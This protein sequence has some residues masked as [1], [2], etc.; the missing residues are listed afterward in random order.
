MCG[1]VGYTGNKSVVDILIDGLKQLEYRGYDSSGIAVKCGDDIKV[2][3]AEGKLENLS[4]VLSGHVSEFTSATCGIGHIRW[5]THGAPT[6]L[7]AH[8]HTCT[9][10][11]LVIVHNGIIE[12]YKEL[13]EQLA[14]DGCTFRSQ[15]DT[16]VVAHLVAKK[17]AQ[18][19]DL[20]EAVR[21]AAK[22]LEG[23]YALCV[24]H[25]DY[26]NTIVA[27]KRN[28]PLLV[29]VGEGEFYAAS[30]VPAIIKHTNR[31]MYL[32]DNE[33]VTLTPEKMLL[34]NS[35]GKELQ[36][37]IET[38]PWEPVALSKRGYKHFMLKE[39]HEQP[40]VI[41]NILVGKLHAPDEHI[42]LNEVKLNKDTLK[43]LNRIQIIAC[44]TSLHAA[45]VGKYLI[46]NF[47]GIAVDVEASSE[48]IY[49]KTVTDNHTLVIGVSQSGETADTLT[50]IKQAKEKG[51]HALIIT[52]R[53]DSAMARLADS[54]IS[55]NAGIEV[56]VAATK[57]Y[58][59]QLMAFYLL[60]LY[61]A[62]VK[63]S[64]DKDTLTSLKAELMLLPQ[65]VER[66]L[67]H[68]E[69]IQKCARAYAAT[70][71]FIYIARGINFPTAL[72]GALK[73]KEISYINAT[74]YPAGELKHGPIA[75]LDETMPVLSILMN[76]VVYEK[77]LSNSEEAK[78][79]NARMIA[80][81]N[82]NDEKL[83]DLFDYII[84]VPEVQELFSPVVAMVPLQLL[85]Y[86]IAEFLGK[87]VD[88]PRNLAKSVTVE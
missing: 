71:D 44:G 16:E 76:G 29:G 83:D 8:P 59:A 33:I 51:S 19:K 87:D 11:R 53:P 42:V 34:V 49:R 5:A 31:A 47:C 68:T 21:L 22:D 54:L 27:T 55:V 48:Y 1:I 88:Q 14:K 73:L 63:D 75:M 57:S 23:A 41:R 17:Y 13:R 9:C 28:A 37:K 52:N 18:T 38:L 79:R 26:K 72:E 25:N 66:I 50:A 2:Y 39:I 45:M 30:D 60:A 40:D 80:L 85:A 10:G 43:N 20:T 15:T 61:M 12:N 77:L 67:A 65:K 32:N 35:D 36:P 69:D 64:V 70:K 3:K 6:V 84:R 62:E 46:E 74:G 56:S 7:N 81:T 82:S 86:Y 24:M 58:I 78:A 4:N